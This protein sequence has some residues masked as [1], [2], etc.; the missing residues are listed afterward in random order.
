MNGREWQLSGTVT[1]SMQ[2]V[3][4]NGQPYQMLQVGGYS[5]WLEPHQFERYQEGEPVTVSGVF[6][7][8]VRTQSGAFEPVHMISSIERSNGVKPLERAS[9]PSKGAPM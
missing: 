4:K 6:V 7:R 1:R 2:G 3:N 9:V 5:F 8:D